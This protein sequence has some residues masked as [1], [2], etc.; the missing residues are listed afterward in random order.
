MVATTPK[1]ALEMEVR[2]SNKNSALA[3]AKAR[4]E[5]IN[6]KVTV[7]QRNESRSGED[8]DGAFAL[9]FEPIATF[10]KDGRRVE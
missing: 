6:R 8:G 9:Y 3:F 7:W 2:F 4:A 10:D 1:Q 5:A